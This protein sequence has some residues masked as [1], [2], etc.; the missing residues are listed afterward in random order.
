MMEAKQVFY[1][2]EKDLKKSS[3]ITLPSGSYFLL[4]QNRQSD[5]YLLEGSMLINSVSLETGAF[6]SINGG[7]VKNPHDESA[8]LFLYEEPSTDFHIEILLEPHDFNWY[9]NTVQGLK[10]TKL[11]DHGHRL[12]LVNW[13]KGTEIPYHT[14]EAGEE[15]LVLKGELFDR[16]SSIKKGEWKRMLA[17]EGHAPYAVEETLILLRNGHL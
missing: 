4:P 12:Y 8:E 15:I 13:E 9:T 3:H 7:I 10:Q 5:I 17:G 16:R 6:V 2:R 1:T 11:R 14:H